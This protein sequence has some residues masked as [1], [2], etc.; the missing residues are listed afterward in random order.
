MDNRQ[1]M[2]GEAVTDP[3]GPGA[4]RRARSAPL[5]NFSGDCSAVLLDSSSL[6]LVFVL[7]GSC[8]ASSFRFWGRASRAPVALWAR[9]ARCR[10]LL[11]NNKL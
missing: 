1:D 11:P 10:M 8:I 3:L 2:C 4:K 9:F 6:E 5:R 7:L